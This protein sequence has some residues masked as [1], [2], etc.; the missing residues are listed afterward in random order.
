M[1]RTSHGPRWP[2][3]IARSAAVAACLLGAAACQQEV[4]NPSIIT[5]G[6]INSPSALPTI[7]D[8]ALGDFALAYTGS[9]ADGSQGIEGVIMYSGLLSDELINSE[10]FPTRI[11]VDRRSIS[12]T[13]ADVTLWFRN[14][15]RSRKSAEFAVQEYRQL[16]TDTT[17]QPGLS[18]MLSLSGYTYLFLAENYCSGVPISNI[19]SDGT[20]QFGQPL[21]TAALIDTAASRFTQALNAAGTLAA[22][23]SKTLDVGLATVGLGR[24]ILDSSTT[25]AGFTAAAAAVAGV[26]TN[27]VYDIFHSNNNTREWNGIYTAMPFA[28]RYSVSDAEGTNTFN[29]LHFVTAPDPR[30]PVY[31]TGKGFDG[32]TP[33]W[34]DGRFLTPNDPDPLATGAEARLIEAEAALA[35]GDTV[36]MLARLNALRAAPPSYFAP[37]GGSIAPMAAITTTGLTSSQ[38]QDLLFTEREHWLFNSGHRLGDLRRLS[39]AGGFYGRSPDTVFPTGA[40][41]KG[42]NYGTD[43]NFP[44]P[45]DETNN[46]NFTGCLSR[47]P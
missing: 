41:F 34:N 9:G 10:T 1:T 42:G 25:A 22:G 45:N 18:E 16:A 20:L 33:Q 5:P 24:A 43:T 15:Q 2:R 44:V 8:A 46:P 27:Y 26:T 37:V 30:N 31:Q 39:H 35:T 17:K 36:T 7:R 21:T 29:A 4:T 11:E 47:N 40:Y 38:V 14:L 19:A 23:A 12:L 32:S 13:N 6:T 3:R 28:K